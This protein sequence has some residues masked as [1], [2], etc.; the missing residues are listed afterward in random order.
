M[1]YRWFTKMWCI[2]ECGLI[3]D[4]CGIM[5][6]DCRY[7]VRYL[8]FCIMFHHHRPLSCVII[9]LNLIIITTQISSNILWCSLFIYT[10]CLANSCFCRTFRLGA[11]CQTIQLNAWLFR[12]PSSRCKDVQLFMSLDHSMLLPIIKFLD[13]LDPHSWLTQLH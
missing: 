3:P 5:I 4:L 6:R 7:D 1:I 10:V 13:W 9:L 12:P 8:W 11:K 2:S